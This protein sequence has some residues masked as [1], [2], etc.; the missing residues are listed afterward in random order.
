MLPNVWTE[1]FHRE[2]IEE[3]KVEAAK[4]FRKFQLPESAAEWRKQRPRI[5]EAL[6]KTLNIRRNSTAVPECRMG[7]EMRFPEYTLTPLCYRSRKDFFVT[8]SLYVPRGRGPF[9][10]VVGMHGHLSDGRLA[11]K[12]QGIAIRLVKSGYV[13]LFV[14]AFGSGER[15]PEHGKFEYHGGLVGGNLLNIGESLLGIQ[16]MDNMAAVDLL[17]SLPF[18]DPERIGATGSSGG[19]NQTMYLAAFDKRIKASV[20]VVSVG[21]YQSYVGGANCICELIPDGLMVCEESALLA[22]AAPNAVMVCNALHD[23]NHTF[24]VAEAARSCTEAQKV[25]T[26]LGVPEKL[27]ARG[28]NGPH[29]YP[30]DLQGAMIGFF[31]LYLKGKGH[32]LPVLPPEAEILAHESVMLYPKG[33][34]DPLVCS[35]PE[36]L[37]RRGNELRKKADGKI[38]GL[39]GILRIEEESIRSAD[40]L[41]TEKGWEKYTVETTRG[42][43]LPFL[44]KRG[45]TE[46]CLI[47][48]APKGKSELEKLPEFQKACSENVSLLVFD[49]WGCGECGYIQEIQNIWI[50]Q[51]QLSRALLWLG[52]RLMGEWV[53]DYLCAAA[54]AKEQLRG[55][56]VFLAGVRDSG[57]A[58]LFASLLAGKSSVSGVTLFDAPATLLR[59]SGQI[60]RPEYSAI[61]CVAPDFFTMALCIPHILEWG[62]LDHA[63]SLAPCPVE[64]VRPREM[65]GVPVAEG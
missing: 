64:W 9:P 33:K 31:D 65:N 29:S 4:R 39:A 49:P 56:G 8:A 62:D 60:H 35:I 3:L 13:V 58:A 55:C 50:E 11:E 20:P 30:A 54:F 18:V 6:K 32:G 53:M 28:F 19:G 42:R 51:H 16:V 10:A 40:Y 48:A 45:T 61:E 21:S 5:L 22:L 26:A 2:I 27:S 17:C 38:S 43:L 37:A 63:A 44:F 25:F 57:V 23:I 15:A 36:Y 47:F 24:Y 59:K 34:R 14:D 1:P 52:R 41:S 12:S 7:K 46:K